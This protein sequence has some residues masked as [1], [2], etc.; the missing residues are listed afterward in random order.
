MT[1]TDS[2]HMAFGANV[3]VSCEDSLWY[4]SYYLDFNRCRTL[5]SVSKLVY[6]KWRRLVLDW[7]W[8]IGLMELLSRGIRGIHMLS[9][10]M[11]SSIVSLSHSITFFSSDDDNIT[12]FFSILSTD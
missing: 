7:S 11:Y 6:F 9:M 12:I 8:P 1:T 5:P 10:I 3:D 4:M 2:N